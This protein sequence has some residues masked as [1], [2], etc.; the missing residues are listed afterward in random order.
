MPVNLAAP[1]DSGSL[2]ARTRCTP[3]IDRSLPSGE[4]QGRRA[5]GEDRER[6]VRDAYSVPGIIKFGLLGTLFSCSST[7]TAT[8]Q[9]GVEVFCSAGG[10]P[11]NDAVATSLSM[12]PEPR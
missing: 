7:D 9:V 1:M 3:D 10:T 11:I 6:A 2:H 8:M 4:V 5:C 12:A